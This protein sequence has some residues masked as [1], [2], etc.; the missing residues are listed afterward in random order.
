MTWTERRLIRFLSIILLILTSAVVIV[1][2][3]R[4]RE[5][6]AAAEASAPA[7]DIASGPITAPNAPVALSYDNGAATLSFYRDEDGIWHWE[8]DKDFPLDN[9]VILEILAQLSDWAPQQTLT[10]AEAMENSG[11]DEPAAS[12]SVTTASG[13]RTS[14][15][16]GKTTDDGGSYYVR[17]NGDESTVYIIADTLYKL[18]EVPI[19]DMCI[20]PQLPALREADIRSIVIQGPESEEAESVSVVLTAQRAERGAATSWR[21]SGANVSDEPTVRALLEDLT[22]LTFTKCVDYRPSDEAASICGFDTPAAEIHISYTA[23]DGTEQ[24][25]ALTVGNR[26]SDGSGRYTRLGED[27]TIYLLATELLDPLMRLA[28]EGLEGA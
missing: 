27:S 13:D 23:A 8:P 2:G 22:A 16:F 5:N 17:R 9:A 7:G 19:Y 12:L 25:L 4:Y 11:L 18:M 15:L 28:A 10:G 6:R 24:S 3:I 1:L 26:L 20:L 14:L 21:S